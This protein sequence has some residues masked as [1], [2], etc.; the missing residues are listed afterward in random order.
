MEIII[1]DKNALHNFPKVLS[2]A[3]PVI[4]VFIITLQTAT[5]QNEWLS[6]FDYATMSVKP[7]V[8]IPGV[9]YVKNDNTT[10]NPNVGY[11]FFQSN[12]TGQPPFNLYKRRTFPYILN[13]LRIPP[14]RFF[15]IFC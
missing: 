3:V 15:L 1:R 9:T 10:F 6:S 14:D 5:A 7:V 13:Q 12:A 2:D 8:H 4:L 11:F